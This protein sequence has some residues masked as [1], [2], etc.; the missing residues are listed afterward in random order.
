M[1]AQVDELLNVARLQSGQKIRLVTRP[2][3]LVALA[4]A[5]ID[6]QQQR[7]QRH[8]IFL[9]TSVDVLRGNWDRSRLERVL[10]NLLS[11]AVKYSLIGGD[12]SVR[13]GI[14]ESAST[15][16]ATL[17]VQDRGAGIPASE[18]PHVF[19]W[20]FRGHNVANDVPG[21]GIGLAGSH[22]IVELHGGTLQVENEEGVGSTF[23]VRLPLPPLPGDDAPVDYA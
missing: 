20:F 6:E 2:T 22:Q 21:A 17:A 19:S 8:R 7:A 12:I 11:N 18:L 15:R 3:D 4:R 1:T 23:T 13:T 16:W 5:S 10:G 9:E 14:E